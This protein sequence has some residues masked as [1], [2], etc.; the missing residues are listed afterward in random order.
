V[1]HLYEHA[2]MPQR[3]IPLSKHA[4]FG[5]IEVDREAC[6]L[7]MSCASLCPKGTIYA[8]G[9]TPILKFVESECVQCGL[10]ESGCPENAIQ[11][12]SRYL[13]DRED[14]FKPVILNEEKVFSCISCG[15]PFATYKMINTITEKLKD[16]Y[17]F[18]G[19]RI[20]QLQMCEDCKVKV[21][22]DSSLA[23]Q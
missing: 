6:T 20:K 18:Q 2:P 19:E 21:Q 15:K 11:L 8:G 23:N 1:E 5:R 13:Y 9:D 22:F 17:M 14:C 12:F 4:P 16:H 10:C 7:C 3:E